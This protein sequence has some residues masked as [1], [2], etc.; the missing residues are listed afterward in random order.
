MP[1]RKRYGPKLPPAMAKARRAAKRQNRSLTKTQKAEVRR[2]V[3]SPAETK[4]VASFAQ[5]Y[6]TGGNVLGFGV[7][8]NVIS[9]GATSTAWSL[10][11]NL[12]QS[13]VAAN[14]STRIG[15]KISNVTIRNDF[16]FWVNPNRAGVSTIDYMCRVYIM[17]AKRIKSNAQVQT[18]PASALLDNGDSTSIDWTTTS[19]VNDKANALYPVNKEVFTCLK[20]KTFRLACNQGQQSGD[21]NPA[22]APLMPA[23]QQFNFS[24]T[25]KHK[26]NLL[27]VDTN[28]GT[29]VPENLNLF[30]F[31]VVWDTNAY[32]TAAVAGNI[33]ATVR[34]HMY[35]KDM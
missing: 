17:K 30:C 33:L 13:T 14:A 4:Y 21:V 32:G 34:N 28:I 18:L 22:V 26:S 35:F 24:Y 31:A 3:V 15:N 9:G 12:V 27:Y 16:Q 7:L 6:Q 10:I 2:L 5:A 20:M 11:P 8:P 29:V 25:H 23:H 1:P 19:A